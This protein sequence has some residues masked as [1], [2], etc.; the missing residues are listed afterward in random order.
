MK[1][2]MFKG[3]VLAVIALVVFTGNLAIAAEG[4]TVKV[5]VK[6]PSEIWA[7]A[8]TPTV[9]AEIWLYNNI[10]VDASGATFGGSRNL[11]VFDSIKWGPGMQAV[12][13]STLANGLLSVRND[14]TIQSNVYS[15]AQT[16]FINTL[17]F[18]P[19]PYGPVIVP[20]SSAEGIHF[21]NIYLSLR[22]DSL[23]VFA[24]EAIDFWLDSIYLLPPASY[25]TFTKHDDGAD[26]DPIFITDTVSLKKYT[27]VTEVRPNIIPEKFE[28]S[29]NYPNPFNPT[30]QI[31]FAIPSKSHVNLV[32]YNALGQRV[33]D[34]VD[35]ELDAG[36]KSV[37]WDGT[38]NSGSEVASGIYLYRIEAQDYAQSKKMILMK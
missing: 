9:T 29:Q 21:A 19:R 26:L 16:G 30:T 4:D 20:S 17:F 12:I 14:T 5:T 36:W 11:L 1:F 38:D 27:K 34:L 33:K 37:S 2:N 25:F 13:D 15:Y 31:E 32:I 23:S 8:E 24:D 18:G 28:L 6:M 7:S 3:L 10:A 22:P 35:E